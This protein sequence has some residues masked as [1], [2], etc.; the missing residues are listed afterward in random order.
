MPF[1]TLNNGL[2]LSI[3]TQGT[4]NW[5]PGL[6][7]NT[8]K[9]ISGHDHSGSG[10]GTQ[11]ATAGL[12]DSAVTTA[13]IAA[14]QVTEPKLARSIGLAPGTTQ[15]PTGTTATI[16]LSTSR[17]H[18]LALLLATGTVTLTLSNPL[19]GVEYLLV[20][21]QGGTP[22]DTWPAAVKW[23]GGVPPVLTD[24]NATALIRLFYY[25]GSYYGTWE[26]VF[27]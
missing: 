19:D 5:G 22:R 9:K 27:A 20:V 7:E 4:R 8:W 24:A 17:N 2:Q 21:S 14:N 13:K 15:T 18:G 26:I 10:N 12:A 6:Y 25:G 23:P 16:D 3:P 1:I 11:I